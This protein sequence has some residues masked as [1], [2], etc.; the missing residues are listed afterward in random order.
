MEKSRTEC[1]NDEEKECDG[2]RGL[3]EGNEKP[4][5]VCVCVRD[6]LST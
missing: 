3:C 4:L 5:C 1:E 2:R 6:V